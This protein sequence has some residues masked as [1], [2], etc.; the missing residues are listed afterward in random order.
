MYTAEPG[1]RIGTLRLRRCPWRLARMDPRSA[2]T[3]SAAD[4]SAVIPGYLAL[5]VII[6]AHLNDT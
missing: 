6:S 2:E 4:S 1:R 5:E 3:S